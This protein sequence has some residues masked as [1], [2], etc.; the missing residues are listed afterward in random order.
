MKVRRRPREG[1]ARFDGTDVTVEKGDLAV[2]LL[3]GQLLGDTGDP[4]GENG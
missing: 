1:A 2:L 4:I 3:E